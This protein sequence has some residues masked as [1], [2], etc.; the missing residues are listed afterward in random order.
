[1]SYFDTECDKT[2]EAVDNFFSGKL[3]PDLAQ[4]LMLPLASRERFGFLFSLWS[5][6]KTTFC[7]FQ[8][9]HG[10]NALKIY[11]GL[12]EDSLPAAVSR[13]QF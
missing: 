9:S 4:G 13:G 10:R 2:F 8:F 3:L 5:G 6:M 1:M 12:L 7:I 11:V